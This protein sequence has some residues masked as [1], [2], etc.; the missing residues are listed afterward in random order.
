[1]SIGLIGGIGPAATNV[2]YQGLIARAAASYRDLELAR[3]YYG[4]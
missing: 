4:N 1:M 3:A 2:Y